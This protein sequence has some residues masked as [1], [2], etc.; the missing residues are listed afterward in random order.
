M[1][2]TANLPAI[3]FIV[4]FQH[5]FTSITLFATTDLFSNLLLINLLIDCT[6]TYWYEINNDHAD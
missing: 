5:L 6:V 3:P 2:S 1:M 4:V